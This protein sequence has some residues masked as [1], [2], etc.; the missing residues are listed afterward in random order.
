MTAWLADTLQMY[1]ERRTAAASGRTVGLWVESAIL[2][3][4][5]SDWPRHHM[6]P[7]TLEALH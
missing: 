2:S 6:L 7:P 3:G 5:L 1:W 4:E